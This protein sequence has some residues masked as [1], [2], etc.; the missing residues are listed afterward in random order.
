V[1]PRAGLDW[2]GKSRPQQDP[3]AGPPG[4]LRDA[5]STELAGPRKTVYRYSFDYIQQTETC[6]SR[7]IIHANKVI[8]LVI[9]GLEL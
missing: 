2:C 5:I 7:K 1:D 6:Y 8:L 4:P 9:R 3:I